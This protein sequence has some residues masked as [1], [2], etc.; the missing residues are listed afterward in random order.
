MMSKKQASAAMARRPARRAELH[1]L[2][3]LTNRWLP[4]E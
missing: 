3:D 4:H 2:G 1:A